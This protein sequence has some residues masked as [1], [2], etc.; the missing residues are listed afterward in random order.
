[1]IPPVLTPL[2]VP[3]LVGVVV[4]PFLGRAA[5]S[6]ARRLVKGTVI[7]GLQ[8]KKTAAEVGGSSRMSQLR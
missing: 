2:A 4:A 7:L 8:A 5:K 1:M 6:L 3:F